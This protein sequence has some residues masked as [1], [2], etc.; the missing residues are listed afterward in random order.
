M[1]Q[2]SVFPEILIVD[3]RQEVK[4]FRN[5]VGL[6]EGEF[7]RDLIAIEEIL[8]AISYSLIDYRQFRSEIYGSLDQLTYSDSFCGFTSVRD[9]DTVLIAAANLGYQIARKLSTEGCYVNGLFP[10]VFNQLTPD[11]SLVFRFAHELLGDRYYDP[12]EEYLLY[13]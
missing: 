10:Y 12:K 5:T 13:L 9:F 8:L 3:V 6:H 4:E 7:M 1:V 11:Y 2:N